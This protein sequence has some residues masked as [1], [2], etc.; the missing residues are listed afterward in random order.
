[1]GYHRHVLSTLSLPVPE[2]LFFVAHYRGMSDASQRTHLY[3]PSENS[4]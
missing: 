1:M 4:G 3:E 2:E